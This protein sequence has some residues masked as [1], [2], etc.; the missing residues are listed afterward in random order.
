M[1]KIDRVI[2]SGATK[3][4]SRRISTCLF[5]VVLLAFLAACGDDLRYSYEKRSLVCA[6]HMKNAETIAKLI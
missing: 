5:G 4:R 1:K 6:I 2:L 3:L